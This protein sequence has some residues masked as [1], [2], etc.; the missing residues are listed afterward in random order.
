[1]HKLQLVLI[2]FAVVVVGCQDKNPV[3]PG[4][5]E[6]L[7]RPPNGAPTVMITG[8]TD[9]SSLSAGK[10]IFLSGTAN[11]AE[12]PEPLKLTWSSSIQGDLGTAE[13]GESLSVSLTPGTHAITASAMDSDQVV[14]NAT[15]TVV[16]TAAQAPTVLI[17]SPGDGEEFVPGTKVTFIAEA[18]DPEDGN[19]SDEARVVKT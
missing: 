3:G 7:T 19:L 15:V 18:V 1:M 12:D 9:G 13:A 6:T 8:P 16:V 14:G 5:I 11:D 17:T 2:V 10:Q 4:S